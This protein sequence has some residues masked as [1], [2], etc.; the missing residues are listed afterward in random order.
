MKDGG[1]KLGLAAG[2]SETG[3][4]E[5]GSV[6]AAGA[7]DKTLWA[8]TAPAQTMASARNPLPEISRNVIAKRPIIQKPEYL[9]Y[10]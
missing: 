8:E 7:G 3:E 1:G 2:A 5:A 10:D 4:L 9:K 6:E